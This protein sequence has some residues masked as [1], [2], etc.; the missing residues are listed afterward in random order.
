MG[1]GGWLTLHFL[2]IIKEQTC[3]LS[4]G[5][6]Y[7]NYSVSGASAW[8]VPSREEWDELGVSAGGCLLLAVGYL[9]PKP[10]SC[11][12]QCPSQQWSRATPWSQLQREWQLQIIDFP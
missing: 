2:D 5:H 12:Q 7:S 1:S 8:D 3:F 10:S 4:S 9:W 11:S 6:L